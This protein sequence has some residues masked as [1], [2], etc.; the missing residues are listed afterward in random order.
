LGIAGPHTVG[1]WY[2]IKDLV[3][4]V[5]GQASI[6]CGNA[7]AG[8][9]PTLGLVTAGVLQPWYR[10]DIG[11]SP[12]A[13]SPTASRIGIWSLI[14]GVYTGESIIFY[15]DAIATSPTAA[16]GVVGGF[17]A[18][19]GRVGYMT[20]AASCFAGSLRAPFILNRAMSASEVA[21]YYNLSKQA[22]YKSDFGALPTLTAEGGVVG[23]YISNTKWQCM[24]TT[25]RTT[26]TVETV[27]GKQC[28]VLTQTTAGY[29]TIGLNAR[30][31]QQ[32]SGAAAFGEWEFWYYH[33]SGVGSDSVIWLW[34]DSITSS[35]QN[36]YYIYIMSGDTFC[37]YQRVATADTQLMSS[38]AGWYGTYN[39]TWAKIKIR[40][41][42]TGDWY[43]YVNDALIPAAVGTNPINNLSFLSL[44]WIGFASG[45]GASG[46]K[47]CL[48]AIDGSN[49][50]IKR[51]K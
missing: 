1:C 9:L 21:A 43:F 19:T 44:D 36:A 30:H 39:N 2:K 47:L 51:L 8:T 32:E 3:L 48:G 29:A 6:I 45:G 22:M 50:L 13:V 4:P 31:M 41:T 10:L 35:T 25:G 18:G 7:S 17:N 11:G 33:P 42:I 40:R 27:N 46:I 38:P 20:T 16:S 26:I 28:K 14:I 34:P 15:H 23:Q 37:F 49:A 5:G 12:F 24:D